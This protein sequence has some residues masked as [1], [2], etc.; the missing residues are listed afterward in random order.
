MTALTMV[1]ASDASLVVRIRAGDRQAFADLYERYKRP[2]FAF[3]YRLLHDR[4]EAEDAV[5][6]AFLKLRCASSEPLQPDRIRSWLFA[7]ARN[8]AYMR[9]R[10]DGRASAAGDD[11]IWEE[12]TPLSLLEEKE[13]SEL[14]HDMFRQLR[15]EYREVLALREFDGLSYAQIAA[16]TGDSESS[17]KS[18]IF[19]ARRAL[20]ARLLPLMKEGT[21]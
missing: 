3:C 5:Q 2:L 6:E 9:H 11:A 17:V 19:K 10:K 18:R 7:V 8:E 15:M 16:V 1:P 13:R 4:A 21:E 20:A 14:V 12:Q